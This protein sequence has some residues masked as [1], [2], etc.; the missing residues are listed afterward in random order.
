MVVAGGFAAAA[1]A[2]NPFSAA[3]GIQVQPGDPNAQAIGTG[4]AIAMGA[5]DDVS[6]GAGLTQDI[7]FAPGYES[8]RAETIAFQTSL[9][10]GSPPA[11]QAYMTSSALR[12]QVA[13]SAA[14]SWLTYYDASESAG[15]TGAASSAAAQVK[16]APNWPA[17]TGYDHPNGLGPAV[18]AVG[19][20]DSS[21]VQALI[22]TGQAG[23]CTALGPFPP[24]GMSTADSRAKL[25]ADSQLGQQDIAAD[26]VAQRL[27]VSGS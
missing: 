9:G 25:A 21:L 5:P 20:G 23:N 18:A 3:T 2:L 1:V 26:P 11:G 8:W 19:A 6:V 15:N 13:E 27:G 7:S 12:F 4:Q 16:A 22:D 24:A 17:I 10:P 14:C